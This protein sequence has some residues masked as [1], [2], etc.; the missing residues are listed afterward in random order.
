MLSIKSI[1]QAVKSV[2]VKELFRMHLQVKQ[3]LWRGNFLSSGYYVITVDQYANEDVIL[4]YI[5][6][7]GA[8]K[9]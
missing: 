1:A 6:N 2:T 4:K 8:Q 3:K 5:W 9:S 7:Q